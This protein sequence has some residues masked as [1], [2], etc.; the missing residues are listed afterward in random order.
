M[1]K[2]LIKN[3]KFI[4]SYFNS[5]D[6]PVTNLMLQKLMYFLEALYMVISDEDKL[7][8]EEFYA[9]DF[10]PV[11]DELYN[12]YKNNGNSEIIIDNVSIDSENEKYIELLHNLFKEFSSYDL[13]ALS[14]A[15]KSPW[16]EVYNKYNEN[17]PHNIV[18]EKQKTKNWFKELIKDTESV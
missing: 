6:K 17:I 15:E 10:G 9:W 14:Y 5:K 13:I 12:T 7:F 3:S 4:I 16:L 18:I 2:D 1:E 8:D 11:N